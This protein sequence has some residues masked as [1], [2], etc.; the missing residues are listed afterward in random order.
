[1]PN[2]PGLFNMG[3]KPSCCED[4]VLPIKLPVLILN[5]NPVKIYPNLP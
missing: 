1:M 5:H 2:V 4:T 3:L